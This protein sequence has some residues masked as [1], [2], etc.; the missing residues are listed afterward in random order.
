MRICQTHWEA[1]RRAVD[2]RGLSQFVSKDGRE[3]A[4]REVRSMES[5]IENA[6]RDMNDWDPLMSMNWNFVGRVLGDVRRH[7]VLGH[8]GDSQ[9][10]MPPNDGHYCPLCV[11]RLDFDSHNTATGKC[12]KSGCDILVHPGDTPWDEIW[13]EGCADAMLRYAQEQGWIKL[14]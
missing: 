4:E 11:V 9:D 6:H 2:L 3:A 13:V 7:H 10:G 5:A 1:C 14:H 8:T 12:G